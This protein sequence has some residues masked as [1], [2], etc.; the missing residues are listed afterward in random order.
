MQH[1]NVSDRFTTFPLHALTPEGAC[2]CWKGSACNDGGKHPAIV[3][4]PSLEPGEKRDQ[5]P[6]QGHGIATGAKSGVFVLDVDVKD[7]KDG[8]ASLASLGEIPETYAVRTPSGGAHF[9]FLHPGKPVKCSSNQLGSGLDIRGDGGYVV[10]PGSRH[11]KGGVYEVSCDAPSAPAPEWLLEWPGLYRAELRATH[12]GGPTPIGPEHPEWTRRLSLA[13]DACATFP[14]SVDGNNGSGACMALV[15]RLVWDLELPRE[16]VSEKVVEIFNPRC[17]PPWSPE[18]IEHKI[19][20]TM[21]LDLAPG[22]APEGF[23]L[24]ASVARA[25]AVREGQSTKIDLDEHLKHGTEKC[26]ETGNAAILLRFHGARL[27]YVANWKKWL[28]WDGSRWAMSFDEAVFELTKDVC[29]ARNAWVAISYMG[30]DE[31]T[32]QRA[33]WAKQ[34]ES[35]RSRQAMVTI[36]RADSKVCIL[37]EALDVDPYLF[38][39]ANGTLDLRTGELLPHDPAQLLTKRSN[40]F[41]DPAAK[42]P[43]W[44][45]FLEKMIPDEHTREYLARA[46]GYSLTGDVTE[47]ALFFLQGGGANGKST[48]VG[49]L[50]D[51]LADYGV[52]AAADLLL[53]KHGESHP[54]AI[55]ALCGRR[56][57][58]CQELE[59]GRSWAEALVKQLTTPAPISA[60]R[61]HEDPWEYMPS[62]KVWVCS[63]PEP[64]IRGTDEGIWR[65]IKK[66][67]FRVQIQDHE[68][69]RHLKYKLRAELSGILAWAV[70]GCL[71]WQ[72]HGLPES[73]EI[74]QAIREYREGEDRIGVFLEERCD[75]G[76]GFQENDQKLYGEYKSWSFES[77]EPMLSKG[78]FRKELEDRKLEA[79]RSKVDRLRKGIK[80]KDTSRAPSGHLRAVG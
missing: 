69:D 76:D 6:D 23:D 31:S 2:T 65:R 43:T 50:Q 30:E 1:S 63:N 72:A 70:R 9:Y 28:V 32:L 19:D 74:V 4:W 12:E 40:V 79:K 21:Q 46:A 51:I 54:T 78:D 44:D 58:L 36:A 5:D 75:L 71:E 52:Q 14:P 67:P 22:I 37:H 41:Y 34:T 13:D 8:F 15:R 47:E 39:V 24:G 60:R 49:V 18:E 77:G 20:G 55:A 62:A 7:G 27:R 59:K 56:F 17:E 64:R 35:L 11:K 73:P 29:A 57:A 53:A 16:I 26:T 80:L 61:M 25:C 38:N 66:I 48:F 45:A 68:K 33:K 10:G 3:A 42:C